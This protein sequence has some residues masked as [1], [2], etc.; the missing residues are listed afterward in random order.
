MNKIEEL[1]HSKAMELGYENCGIIPVDMMKGYEDRLKERVDKLPESEV[2]YK[3][4]KRLVDFLKTYPWAKSIVVAV[5][6]YN[7]YIVPEELKGHI[8]KAYLFDIRTDENTWEYK[9]GTLMENYLK[10]L[11]LNTAGNRKFGIVGMRWAALQAGVGVIRKNNFFYTE[12]GSWVH[13]DAWLTDKDMKLIQKTE[14]PEC[15]PNCRRCIEACSTNS[16][17]APYTM[18]PVKC[19]SFLTTFGGRDLAHNQSAEKLGECIYGCD[20]CQN[21]CPMN[22]GKDREEIHFSGLYDLAPHLTAVGIMDMEEDYYR[23]YIQPKFFYLSQDELWKW[24]VNALNYMNNN[25]KEEY[26]RVIINSC[27]STYKG[28]KELA[29]VICER[30]G[31]N[32]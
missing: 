31:F 15:P 18:S 20:L 22:K 10:E 6:P 1:I 30:R 17:T 9:S 16:L 13:I 19:I 3:G 24:K 5:M 7:R 12:S 8:A 26:K 25:Y 2:F 23:K 32:K 14:L 29:E 21:A 28:V 11:G 4:Q 27:D